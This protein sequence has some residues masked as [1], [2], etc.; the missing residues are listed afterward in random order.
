MKSAMLGTILI[1]SAALTGGC[2]STQS[3]PT[4]LIENS[5]SSLADEYRIGVDD[6]IQVTV[7]GNEAL[8]VSMPVRPD[9]K[10]SMPLIGDVKAGGLT[11]EEMSDQ[12]RL[13]LTD[14]VRNPNVTVQII[15]LRSH[16]YLS[17]VRITGAV[18]TPI[19]IPYRQGMTILDAVLAAGGVT[20]YAA[21]G[22]TML[23]RSTPEGTNV[24]RI[25][26][27]RILNKGDI[28]LNAELFPGDT[29]TVPQ[30]TF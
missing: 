5:G 18:Q 9:G 30:R 8:S 25:K 13:R 27:D 4:N 14:F 21:P 29:I 24:Y 15:E 17:R 7:W 12:I 28:A 3:L 23:Q 16:E 10:I 1:F 26:L 20:P 6:Q 2:S 19:S 11:S 22:R